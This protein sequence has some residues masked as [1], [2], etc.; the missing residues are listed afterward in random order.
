MPRNFYYWHSRWRQYNVKPQMRFRV[1]LIPGPLALSMVKQT[2]LALND[3]AEW[4]GDFHPLAAQLGSADGLAELG[5]VSA[6][7]QLPPVRDLRSLATFLAEYQQQILFPFEL[8]TILAA[9]AHTSRHELRELIALDQD[10]AQE[11]ILRQFAEASWRVGQTQIQKLRPLRDQR[12]VQRYLQAIEGNLAHGW[13]TLVYGL[14]LEI[15]SL[16]LRQGLLG[17]CHQTLR[18]FIYAAARR[19]KL[20][21][22]QCRELFDEL[23]APLPAGVENLLRQE[24]AA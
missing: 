24:A 18:G 11:P 13:H 9:H 21:E 23:A 15:Y 8:P 6:S 12:M 1:S 10:L 16:P 17:Y 7:L 22:H 19:L 3:A 4:L 20:S 14:T 5:S 2:Q